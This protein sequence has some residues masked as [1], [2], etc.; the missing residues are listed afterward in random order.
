MLQFFLCPGRQTLMV[1]VGERSDASHTAK[2]RKERDERR[3]GRQG[4]RERSRESKDRGCSSVAHQKPDL[5]LN[6]IQ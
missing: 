2:I 1:C 6:F 3:R 4:E 5:G